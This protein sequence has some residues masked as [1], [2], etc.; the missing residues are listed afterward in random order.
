MPY[1]I[2]FGVTGYVLAIAAALIGLNEKA[3]FKL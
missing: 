1:H 2:Y 3:I